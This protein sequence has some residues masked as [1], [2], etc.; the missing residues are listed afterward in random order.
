MKDQD[1][2]GFLQNGQINRA[3]KG[4]Y[5]YMPDIRRHVMSNNGSR[6]DAED[7]YQESLIVLY[8]KCREPE[9]VLSSS[10]KTYLFAVARN[11]WLQELKK[12]NRI[13][14]NTQSELQDDTMDEEYQLIQV[15]EKAFGLLGESCQK[16]LLMFYVQKLSMIEIAKNLGFNSAQVAKNQKYR[17]LEKA[18]SNFN[19]LKPL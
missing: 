5:V 12:R 18:R 1:I 9:F 17:C 8:K 4:L 14:I 6:E 3:V 15:A 2:I 11:L 19:T 7:I 10:L 13:Q 16:L